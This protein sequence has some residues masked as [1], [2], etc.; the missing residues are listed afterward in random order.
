VCEQGKSQIRRLEILT[1]GGQAATD[2]EL[3]LKKSPAAA[4]RQ[5]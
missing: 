4:K 1:A 2:D 5:G 3:I